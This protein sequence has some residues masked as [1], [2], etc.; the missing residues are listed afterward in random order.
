VS[1]TPRFCLWCGHRLVSVRVEGYRRRRCVRCRWIFYDNA[2][3]AVVGIIERAGRVLLARRGRPP[4]E[5][6]WDLPGGFLEG[7]ELPE[8]GLERE[9]REELAVRARRIRLIGFAADRYGPRGFHVLTMVYRVAIGRAKV[10]P[11]DDV[12]DAQWFDRQAVPLHEVSF[13]SMRRLLRDYL[14]GRTDPLRGK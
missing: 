2:V 8:A 13:P 9:L 5:G 4:Y 12:S 1:Y 7:G 10:R 3:P 11:G 14:E 6:S